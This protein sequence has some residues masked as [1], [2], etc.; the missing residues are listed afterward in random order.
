[1]RKDR[2]KPVLKYLLKSTR[3]EYDYDH[4]HD[5]AMIYTIFD[6]EGE[7]YYHLFLSKSSF[8]YRVFKRS[9]YD[10]CV[11]K[12]NLTIGESEY[13]FEIYMKI[14]KQKVEEGRDN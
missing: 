11:D 13:L 12:F 3:I 4:P 5:V 6:E 7:S 9:F 8:L 10:Y 14:L 2:I 1:M